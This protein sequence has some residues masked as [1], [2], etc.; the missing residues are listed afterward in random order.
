MTLQKISAAVALLCMVSAPAFAQTKA[1]EPDYTLSYNA[2]VVTDYRYRGLSQTSKKL[3]LQGGVDFVHKNGFYAGTWASTVKWTKDDA[4][5]FG[6]NPGKTNSGNNN[7]EVDIYGGYK[8]EINK[9]FSFD[10]GALQ[11]WYPGNKYEN[12]IA[13]ANANTL[14]LYGAVTYGPVTAK[15]SRSA[16]NL[17]GFV[18][19]SGSGYLDLSASFEIGKGLTLVPHIGRQTIRNSSASNYTDYSITLNKDF[20]NGFS[21]SA[22]AVSTDTKLYVTSTGKNKGSSGL[23]LGAKYSF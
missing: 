1:P 5:V 16:S 8:G 4:L 17:F 20:G 7:L 21:A 13:A 19:S 14:E 3:A 10:V 11:Y 9:D 2:G 18:N 15:Y 22:A 23:V 6:L 12:I